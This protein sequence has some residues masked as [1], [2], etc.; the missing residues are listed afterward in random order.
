M[1][2]RTEVGS[3][4]QAEHWLR[5]HKI[6]VNTLQEDFDIGE[7]IQAGL[8]SG[9]NSQLTFGRFEGALAKYNEIVESALAP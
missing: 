2:P 5:N 1:A 4:E 7:S 3:Q 9:A 6:T 8:G